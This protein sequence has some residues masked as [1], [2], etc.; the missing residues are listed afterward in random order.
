LLFGFGP[1]VEQHEATLGFAIL[2]VVRPGAGTVRNWCWWKLVLKCGR[3]HG[4]CPSP[5][6][7]T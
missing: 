2:Q 6:T 7:L 1:R 5:P 4:M 3:R